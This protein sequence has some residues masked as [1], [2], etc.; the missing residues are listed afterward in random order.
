MEKAGQRPLPKYVQKAA[1][2]ESIRKLF[3][4][5]FLWGPIAM[6][7]AIYLQCNATRVAI[8]WLLH[9]EHWD[10][11][12]VVDEPSVWLRWNGWINSKRSSFL[13][14]GNHLQLEE[15]R[16]GSTC[17]RDD[18]QLANRRSTEEEEA[19]DGQ[20]DKW[21]SRGLVIVDPP[22]AGPDNNIQTL[23]QG[24]RTWGASS[25]PL[26]DGGFPFTVDQFRDISLPLL[27]RWASGMMDGT[28][29]SADEG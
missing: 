21:T 22:L 15:D 13:S 2:W 25:C 1:T 5:S 11:G 26:S 14:T 19:E 6:P 10:W 29:R 17:Q 8:Q 7:S 27:W 23:S 28:F 24:M 18:E 20:T 4:Q 16:R 3:V 12:A 9:V